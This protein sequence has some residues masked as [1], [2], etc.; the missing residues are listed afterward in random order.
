MKTQSDETSESKQKNERPLVSFDW[1]IKKLLRNKANFEVVE[2]FLSELFKRPIKITSVL[3][4]ESNKEHAKDKS[5]KVDILVENDNREIILI[6]LQFI[7]EMDYFHRLLYGSSKVVVEHMVQSDEYMKIRK[8]YSINIVY[9]DLGQGQD[10]IYAGKM[11]FQGVRYNDRLLLSPEQRKIFNMI[12]VGE[13]FPE[14]YVIKVKKFDDITI[15]TF[16]E[17]IYFLKHDRIKEGFKAKGLLKACEVLDY[18]R[19]SPEE[20]ADY[21]EMQ[22]VKSHQLSQVASAK[23]L[24]ESEAEKKYVTVIEEQGKVI[25]EQSKAIEEQGKAIEEKDKA[26]EK[27]A[28][29]IAELKRRLNIL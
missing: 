28:Q 16:D 2:G 3:E 17:W 27:Q 21:D 29:E 25:E 9:F 1:A 20:K 7:F 6:E 22:S 19:L 26:I 23:V 11:I 14:Y 4:S 13:I 15:D 5:N 10:Y 12:E 18:S 8:V 24:G